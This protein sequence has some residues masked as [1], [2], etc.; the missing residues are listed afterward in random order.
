V[1]DEPAWLKDALSLRIRHAI[2]TGS[3]FMLL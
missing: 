1:K 2:A 3:C